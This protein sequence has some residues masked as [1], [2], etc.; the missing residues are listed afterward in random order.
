MLWVQ[1]DLSNNKIEMRKHTALVITLKEEVSQSVQHLADLV[2]M[3]KLQ[4]AVCTD[5][6][7]GQGYETGETHILGT[8]YTHLMEFG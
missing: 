8:E 6:F 3:W 4:S 7:S 2:R 5:F 1:F